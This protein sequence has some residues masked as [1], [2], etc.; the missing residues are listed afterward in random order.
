MNRIET[1]MTSFEKS[2]IEM[3]Y[4]TYTAIEKAQEALLK[5]DKSLA[6][7]VIERDEHLN[8]LEESI[9]RQAIE[10]FTLLQPVAKDLRLL[11]GGIKIA[12]DLERIGDYGKNMGRFVIKSDEDITPYVKDL[13]ALIAVFLTNFKDALALIEKRDVKHAHQVALADEQ[14]DA[15]FNRFMQELNNKTMKEK[16]FPLEISGLARNIERAGDH[17]KNIA[18]EVIYIVN[19]QHIDFG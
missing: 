15:S 1:R 8:Y 17:A 11:I 9:N 10:I 13:K 3:A 12:N 16:A 19:G 6:L 18:E 4:S 7:D 2:L 14:L 5:N